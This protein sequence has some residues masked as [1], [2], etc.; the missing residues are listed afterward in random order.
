MDIQVIWK[1]SSWDIFSGKA[2]GPLARG[3]HF[4]WKSSYHNKS[5]DNSRNLLASFATGKQNPC[6]AFN[7][8]TL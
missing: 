4:Q 8:A 7:P 3:R 1:S 2:S 6:Q 5:L